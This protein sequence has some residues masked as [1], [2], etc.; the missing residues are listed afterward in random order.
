MIHDLFQII[1]SKGMTTGEALAFGIFFVVPYTL[2][3]FF[4]GRH[5]WLSYKHDG[6]SFNFRITDIWAAMAGFVP[7]ILFIV[8]TI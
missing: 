1:L 8:F 5:F 4:V 2:I 3:L 6:K 7:T